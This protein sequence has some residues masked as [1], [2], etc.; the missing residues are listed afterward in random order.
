MGFDI[1]VI[2]QKIQSMCLHASRCHYCHYDNLDFVLFHN[3]T[4][5]PNPL[6][7][8]I[9]VNNLIATSV[10]SGRL[11]YSMQLGGL[12]ILVHVRSG[13]DSKTPN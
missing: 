13:L 3:V 10:I 11:E 8:C 9:Y 5:Y 6:L 7:S 1:Q 12:L 4:H 2:H